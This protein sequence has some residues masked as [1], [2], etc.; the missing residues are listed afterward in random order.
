MHVKI[1]IFG[2]HCC[3]FTIKTKQNKKFLGEK[4]V[5]GILRTNMG[6]EAQEL[7]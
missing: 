1:G 6:G 2:C 3:L 5:V 4:V 7:T